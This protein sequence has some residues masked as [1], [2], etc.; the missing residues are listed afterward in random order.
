MRHKLKYD[1]ILCDV[2]CSGDG[3]VRKNYDVWKKWKI[4][5]GNNFNNTQFRILKRGLELL[6]KDGLLVY[7]TCSLNPVEDEAVVSNMLILAEG[8]VELVDVC[9]KLPGLKYK[10]GIEDWTVM[11]YDSKKEDVK[12]IKPNEYEQLEERFKPNIR[13]TLFPPKNIEKL[14]IKR[15]MRILPHYQNTGG[16]FVAVFRKIIDKL[17]WNE[18]E[19][20]EQ[21]NINDN[22]KEGTMPASPP[23]KKRRQVLNKEDPFLFFKRDEQEWPPI[24]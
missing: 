5:N 21:S 11:A 4:G 18:P 3:T 23:K 20:K 15:C 16:F 24:K 2:P 10:E 9:D 6:A 19:I 17:P 7:S 22:V 12:V 8:A 14:N 13:L 1:R